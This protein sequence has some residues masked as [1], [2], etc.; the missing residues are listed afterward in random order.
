M[1]QRSSPLPIR[2]SGGR[3]LA[4]GKL[5]SEVPEISENLH[6][7]GG[8]RLGCLPPP[9]K[10]SN[11]RA[12]ILFKLLAINNT[13]QFARPEVLKDSPSSVA[14]PNYPDFLPFDLVEGGGRPFN[15][16]DQCARREFRI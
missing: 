14:Q 16:L 3:I 9:P 11:I 12:R 13:R 5:W 6:R 15:F 8:R 10:S 1:T 2:T 7:C 4:A